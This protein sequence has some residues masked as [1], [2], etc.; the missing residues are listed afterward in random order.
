M[1]K[2][3]I[4]SGIIILFFSSNIY[5]QLDEQTTIKGFWNL[6]KNAVAGEDFETMK[7]LC[8]LPLLQYY[9]FGKEVE[10][11]DMYE[12]F[13]S[14]S[15]DF[16]IF[17]AEI[18]KIK[19]P[20]RYKFVDKKAASEF[21]NRFNVSSENEVYFVLVEGWHYAGANLYIIKIDGMYYIIGDDSWESV[22]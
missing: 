2:I 6:F 5:S 7:N 14:F 10:T 13:V 4:I 20:K 9:Y 1:K 11:N 22:G 19:S 21:Y 3:I 15:Q 12:Y 16:N 17:K 18:K 8:R